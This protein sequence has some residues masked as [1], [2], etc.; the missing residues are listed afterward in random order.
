MKRLLI[1]PFYVA[2]VVMMGMSMAACSDDETGNGGDEGTLTPQEEALK[3]AITEYVDKTVIPTYQG[4]ADASIELY[5]LCVDIRSKHTAGTLTTADVQA[6]CDAWLLTRDYWEKSEAWLYG[7]AGDYYIDPH[8]DSWPLD[9]TGMDALL[10]NP[11]QMAQMDDEGVYVGDYLGYALKGFHPLEYLLFELTNTNASGG[12]TASSESVAHSTD[13]TV[14]ELNYMVG[15]A[16]DLR[17]QCVLL[18]ACWAGTE[19]VTSEKQQILTNA[20]LDKGI[21]Y[22]EEMKNSGS[23]GSD[24][25][26]YLDA[27]Y[28]I[29]ISGIQNIANE[30]GNVKIG[31]P[32]G[33]GSGDDFEYDPNYIESPYSLNSIR[34]FLGNVI[35]VRNAYEGAPEV[36]GTIQVATYSLS[37]YIASLD[38]DLDSRVRAAIQDAYDKISLMQ[39]PFVYTCGAAEYDTINQD[40]VDACNVMNDIF[41]EVTALL[42]ANH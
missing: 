40:A 15:L 8:I 30:V 11:A 4:M 39:E 31:N 23:A 19:N 21:N 20:D 7:P 3:N 26:N 27:A 14:E 13:Y 34:D 16:G 22:G 41:S 35:S 12:A 42:Q 17:N 6:A 18:E 9:Q 38:A 36:D 32:T 29:I 28:D 24:Y 25:V 33:K 5:G 37:D 10:N 2:M 1:F